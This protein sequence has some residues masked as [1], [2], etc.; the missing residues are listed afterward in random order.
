MPATAT[1]NPTV[2]RTERGLTVKGTRLTLYHIMDYVRAGC[3]RAEL[4]EWFPQITAAELED[5]LDY[6][7]TNR[8]E[9]EAEYEAVVKRD[10]EIRQYWEER[11]RDRVKPIDPDT[12]SPERRALWEKLQAWKEQLKAR[13]QN[14]D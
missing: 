13:D 5:I 7:E 12:L 9:F 8:A 6:I 4:L 1:E 10:E 14:T 11:N 2:V 3:S